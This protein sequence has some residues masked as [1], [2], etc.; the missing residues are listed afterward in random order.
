MFNSKRLNREKKTALNMQVVA[1]DD[2]YR[3]AL[4]GLISGILDLVVPRAEIVTFP[5]GSYVNEECSTIIATKVWRF[6]FNERSKSMVK[7]GKEDVSNQFPF[8]CDQS[9]ADDNFKYIPQYTGK[10]IQLY[11]LFNN[12]IFRNGTRGQTETERSVQ[13]MSPYLQ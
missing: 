1:K 11:C 6:L 7:H 4:L 13:A 12:I 8:L 2:P 10:T 9:I 3:A 5:R